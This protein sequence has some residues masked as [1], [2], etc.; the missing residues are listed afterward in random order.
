MR[1]SWRDEL[2]EEHVRS[3][4]ELWRDKYRRFYEAP[5][6][7]VF[8][9]LGGEVDRLVRCTLIMHDVG[10]LTWIYQAYLRG[11]TGLGYYRHEI[12]SSAITGVAFSGN[13]WCGYASAAVLLSH[14]PILLGQVG[15]V[16]ERYF[17]VTFAYRSLK[18]AAKRGEEVELEEDGVAVINEILREEGFSESLA[19]RYPIS[20]CVEALK[21][22]IARTALLGDRQ[23]Q[24]LR[25]AVLSHILTLLDSLSASRARG[26][27][28]GGTFVSR[29]ARYAEVGELWRR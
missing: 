15:R 12:V 5:L 9:G 25:V 22:T 2:I 13:P 21:A 11:E 24:R 29:H 16:G 27:D 6:A 23:T 19:S 4:I 8:R 28:E 14:E 20:G 18:L 17:S 10:K 26:D 1:Y 7:R 3:M